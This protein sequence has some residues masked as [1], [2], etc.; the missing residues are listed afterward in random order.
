MARPRD[1]YATVKVGSIVIRCHEFERMLAF[2]QEALHYVPTRPAEGGWVI[3]RDPEGRGPRIS[4]DQVP[5]RRTGK[6]GW[7]HLDLYTTDQAAEVERL[8]GIGA[9]RYPWRYKPEDD[10]VVLEDPDG[11][12]FCV[13]EV[14]EGTT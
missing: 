12:L 1:R 10:F 2:W 14:P 8:I 5:A 11:N 13:V 3:L 7:L 6:R 4:L 9:K